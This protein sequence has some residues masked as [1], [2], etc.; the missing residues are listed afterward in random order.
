MRTLFNMLNS[1][2]RPLNGIDSASHL[3]N[4][5]KC[6]H[7]TQFALFSRRVSQEFQDLRVGSDSKGDREEN[8]R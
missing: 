6:I 8:G 4:N 5:M 1:S 7:N 3:V 2:L